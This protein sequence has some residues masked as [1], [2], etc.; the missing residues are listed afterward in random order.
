M[1]Y[2]IDDL[3]TKKEAIAYLRQFTKK[4]S[5]AVFECEVKLGHIAF[6][7]C[8]KRIKYPVW[9]L[10]NWRKSTI[11]HTDYIKEGKRGMH[12]YRSQ[13]QMAGTSALENLYVQT[14]GRKPSVV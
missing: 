4:M 1:N 13:R 7:T 3:L 9:E 2:N 6:R 5:R 8:G 12:T 10:D 14:F 11:K